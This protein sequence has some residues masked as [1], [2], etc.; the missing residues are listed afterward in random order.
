MEQ[1]DVQMEYLKKEA[2]RCATKSWLPLTSA[3][4]FKYVCGYLPTALINFISKS[5]AA[6]TFLLSNVVGPQD[7]TLLGESVISDMFFFMPICQ[8]SMSISA[9][10]ISCNGKA[11][12]CL[13]ADMGCIPDRSRLEDLGMMMHDELQDICNPKTKNTEAA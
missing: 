6:A 8:E 10:I 12:I 7:C 2:L 3:C 1:T 4:T 5:K 13:T 11:R 9:G